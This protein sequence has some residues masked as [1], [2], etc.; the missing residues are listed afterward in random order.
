MSQS[1][2]VK[3]LLDCEQFKN[4]TKISMKISDKK[5]FSEGLEVVI[6]RSLDEIEAIRPI[7]EKMQAKEPYLVIN[8]DINRY[9]SV[10]KA[11]GDDVK[12]YVM[13]LE[14]NGRPAAMMIGRIKEHQLNLKL[15]Y[16]TV[17][18]PKLR[19]LIV[20]YGGVLGQPD[21]KLYSLLIGELMK[22]LSRR[23]A[24]MVYFNHLR[25]DSDIYRLSRKTPGVLSCGYFPKLENH[26]SMSV[27]ENPDCFYQA[28]SSKHRKHLR[29]YVRK[30]ER[31]Y[32]GQVKMI[33]YSK[34]DELDEAIKA[35]S[36]ISAKTY[37]NAMG[38]GFVDDF[39]T[40][41]LL[42][43]AAKLGWLRAHILYIDDEPSAYRFAL[44][45]GRTYFADGIGFDPKWSKWRVGTVLFMNVIEDLCKDS[46]V[47]Y[48][49]FGFGDADYK[50]SYGD[51]QWQ[52]ASV[53]IFA[54]RPYPIFVNMLRTSTMGL[55]A[56]LEY[57]L[58][59]TGLVGWVKRRWR[60]LLQKDSKR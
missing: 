40:R 3:L 26:W 35:A 46:A 60:N 41:T 52:E 20:V 58:N 27:P 18:S 29:Q 50:R 49:D 30:L 9:L 36:Q 4:Y 19:C 21:G 22:A 51:K 45:H 12:P 37:Q 59:K 34:E 11:S 23:E 16:K 6:A 55:N 31:A 53:Y 38:C 2:T 32:P 47:E 10:L 33:T 28:R 56:S 44:H 5:Y 57:I 17:L 7:W 39:R 15:G 42:S 8:A 43:V 25:T 1:V 13:F 48:Y 24:D 14:Q 54:A